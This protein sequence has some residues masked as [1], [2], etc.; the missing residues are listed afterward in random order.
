MVSCL[1]GLAELVNGLQSVLFL[2]CLP[3]SSRL[4]LL[5]GEG[6]LGEL[7]QTNLFPFL[8]YLISGSFGCLFQCSLLTETLR[9]I[10]DNSVYGVHFIGRQG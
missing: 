4:A 9:E 2:I 3:E 1:W 7:T 6:T 10:N 5:F 8:I